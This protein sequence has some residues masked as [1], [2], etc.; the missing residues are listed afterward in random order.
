M[1]MRAPAWLAS[2]AFFGREVRPVRT[3]IDFQK[4]TILHGVH[5]DPLDVYLIARPLEKRTPSGMAENVEI[6]IV[7]R[8]NAA[9]ALKTEE[10][11]LFQFPIIFC[12]H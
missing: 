10:Q 2:R 9:A 1:E 5:N 7:H 6:A 12:N 4:T 8:P 3:G 11:D